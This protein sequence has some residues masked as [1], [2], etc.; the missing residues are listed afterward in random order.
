M[1]TIS[2]HRTLRRTVAA[3][4]AVTVAAVP[5]ALAVAPAQAAT[6]SGCTVTPLRPVFAGF[7]SSGVKQVR[8]RVTATCSSN[9][10][11]TVEQRRYEDDASPDP[12]D[13]LG[14]SVLVHS[15]SGG[16]T[17]TLST[18]RSLPDTEPGNEEIYQRIRF[19]VSSNGVTSAWTGWQNSPILSIPN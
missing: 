16:A 14:S 19:R 4:I 2:A 11:L 10:V 7:N 15:F 6:G 12:D 5:L 8:Y 1:T 18:T 3:G 9:R 17:V 13:F